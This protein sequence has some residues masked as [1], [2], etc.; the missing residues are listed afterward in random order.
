MNTE[1]KGNV[2][3][4]TPTKSFIIWKEHFVFHEGALD[5]Y[6]KYVG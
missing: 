4:I 6:L 5:I 1:M 3:N 2:W